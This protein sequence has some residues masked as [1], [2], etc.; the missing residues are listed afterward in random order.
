MVMTVKV[1][2]FGDVIA[3]CT[4]DNE[5]SENLHGRRVLCAEDR[6]SRSLRNTIKCLLGHTI[7]PFLHLQSRRLLYVGDGGIFFLPD[8]V[9]HLPCIFRVSSVLN[10]EAVAFLKRR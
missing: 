2:V 3:C 4:V 5:F 7:H 9:F 6:D 10:V 8:C 1:T